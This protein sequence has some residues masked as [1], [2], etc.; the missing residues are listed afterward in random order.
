MTFRR[1]VG[2]AL[3]LVAAAAQAQSEPQN[4]QPPAADPATAEAEPAATVTA[5]PEAEPV[6][7]VELT[8]AFGPAEPGDA[9]RGAAKAAV[10]GACHGMDGNSADPQNPKLAGQHE[11]YLARHLALYKSGGRENSIMA[12]FAAPLSPQDMR[13]IGAFYADKQ[14]VPGMADDS[15]VT[16]GDFVGRRFY[17]IGQ[18]LYRAG[19]P[20][21][22]LPACSAC[23]GPAGT[24]NPAVPYPQLQGQHAQY[25]AQQLRAFRDGAVYGKD[26]NADRVMA[27]VA[28]GLTDTEIEALATYIEGLHTGETGAIPASAA[29]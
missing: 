22:A 8:P 14:V 26:G 15:P 11:G 16:E 6:Q 7:V 1:L 27:A 5:Q 29:R 28:A 12:G 18:Q 10:C 13:D 2:I 9:Q 20:G 3:L 25:T 17:E 21:R 24:G 23:H 19:D 4:A